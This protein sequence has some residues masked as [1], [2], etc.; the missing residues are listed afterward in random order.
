MGIGNIVK[1]T[2]LDIMEV[3][4]R[5]PQVYEEAA[6][7]AIFTIVNGPVWI[8]G[9][10]FFADEAV[11]NAGTGTTMVIQI[12]GVPAD[13]AF[14][15]AIAT[16]INGIC[17]WPLITGVVPIPGVLANPMPTLLA[18]NA[19]C[20]G[21]LASPG[22]ITLEVTTASTVGTCSFYCLYYRMHPDSEIEV[23]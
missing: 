11:D 5:P 12:C 8:K 14:P 4:I 2:S 1:R 18:I 13:S 15:T 17:V 22:N 10:F 3:V 16:P 6:A 23:A 19:A 20:Y 21:Q 9:L 7:F